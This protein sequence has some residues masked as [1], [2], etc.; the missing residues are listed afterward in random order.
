M[1]NRFSATIEYLPGQ[2]AAIIELT[3]SRGEWAGGGRIDV[4][5]INGDVHGALYEAGYVDA[6]RRAA[7]KGG[8]LDRFSEVSR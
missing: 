5:P 4:R 2:R 7:C 6:S 1:T 3:D 8:V